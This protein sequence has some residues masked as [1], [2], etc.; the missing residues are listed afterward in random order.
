MVQILPI[1]G[2]VVSISESAIVIKMQGTS[3]DETY[4]IAKGATIEDSAD[5][6]INISDIKPGDKVG[7]LVDP[8]QKIAAS[9]R[10]HK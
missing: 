8:N 9:I 2:Q 6:R 10:K 7:L 3:K 5:K 4:Q 1:V